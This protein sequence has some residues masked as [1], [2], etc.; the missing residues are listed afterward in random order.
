M[1]LYSD[2]RIYASKLYEQIKRNGVGLLQLP[3][4]QG[5]TII[6]L[7]VVADILAH[8]KYPRPVILVT[9]KR[10]DEELFSEALHGRLSNPGF[11]EKRPWI[12]DAGNVGGLS[13]LCKGRVCKIGKVSCRSTRDII[14]PFPS[15]AVIIFDEIHRFVKRIAQIKTYNKKISI[16]KQRKYLLLSATPVNPVRISMDQEKGSI[17]FDKQSEMED[18]LI[19][20]SFTIL[21][22]AMINLSTLSKKDKEQYVDLLD[23]EA[24]IALDDF[25]GNLREVM[26][27]LKP[28]PGPA[29]LRELGP[30]GSVPY[31]VDK[32]ILNP[33]D[34]YKA[35]KGLLK[36][37]ENTANKIG[38]YYCAERMALAG[39]VKRGRKSVG[40]CK[41]PKS[42]SERGL[43]H[44]QPAVPYAADTLAGLKTLDGNGR[45]TGNLLLSGKIDRLYGFIKKIWEKRS[46]NKKWRILIYCAHR[47]SVAALAAELERRFCED[48]IFCRCQDTVQDVYG[49]AGSRRIVWDTEGY[50][51]SGND[52][53]QSEETLVLKFCNTRNQIYC[54]GEK[55]KCKCPLGFVLVT[56]DRLSESIDLHH[57][58]EIM[59][60]FDLDWSPL[61][62]IQRYGRLWRIDKSYK[63]R[64]KPPAVFHMIQPGSVDDEIIWRLEKRWQ[65]LEMLKLGLETV[66]LKH[67]LGIRIY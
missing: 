23:K 41:L 56:S 26:K 24:E 55:N 32:L 27:V 16:S 6:A 64:P 4:G 5:K 36:F 43:F 38:L 50:S 8:S 57:S 39:A 18:E 31:T 58:C 45:K 35:V 12:R 10:E 29:T 34:Y 52:D 19:K 13:K 67:A 30:S 20:D 7:K 47:G 61:R 17:D 2:Q 22:K 40:F 25:A 37:H 53:R 9:R 21:Y 3:T 15:G 66:K 46:D 63:R 59:I 62:M 1:R 14:N 49:A 33:R 54:T 48:N 11:Y 28:I 65:K 44:F 60:H 42:F 51:K